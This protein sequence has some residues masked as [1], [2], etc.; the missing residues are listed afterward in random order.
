M[1]MHDWTKATPGAYHFFHQRWISALAD[2]LN[3][4]GLPP[5]YFAMS[6][7][8]VAGWEP[9][10]LALTRPLPDAP[11]TDPTAV[12]TLDPPP[13]T[14]FVVESEARNHA[15][16]ADYLTVRVEEGE[17]VA[18]IEIVS[19]GNKDSREDVDGLVRKAIEF[20]D[21]GVHLVIVDPFP[22]GALDRDGLHKAI[23]DEIQ[24]N[25]F[26]LPTD[27]PLTVVSYQASEKV[28]GYVEPIAVGD[29]Q[30][31]VPLYLNS[32]GRYVPCPLEPSYQATWAVYPPALKA[33]V[34]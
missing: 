30:P 16:R 7:R 26:T 14:R 13:R 10:V 11:S 23:W 6:E 8:R 15:R 9:D 19:P 1:P 29:P 22:P 12:A 5:G 24:E 27:K 20:L 18:V 17:V 31:S 33:A 25:T 21:R 28:I 3:L 2:A 34:E 32:T 4:G